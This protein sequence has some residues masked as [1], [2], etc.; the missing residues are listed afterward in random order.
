MS[1]GHAWGE[2]VAGKRVDLSVRIG[3]L[4]LRNPILTASGTFGYGDEYAH[5]VKIASLGGVVTKTVTVHPR[6]GNGPTRIAETASGMLNSIGLENVGL[7]RFRS[8][9]L[10]RLR[11]LDATVVASIG[12]ETPEELEELL[13]AL[14]DE[15]GVGAFEVNFSCPNVAAG[16]ARYWAD[17]ARLESTLRR[18]RHLTRR[19]L[20]AKLSPDVTD[21]RETAR[22]C[23]A[24]GADAL[25]CVN[26][27][28]GMAIDLERMRSKLGKAT[29]GLS[30]PAVKPMALARCWEASRAVKIPVIG[31]GGISSGRDALEFIAAG[32]AAV[33]VGTATFVEPGASLRV[34]DEMRAWLAA[35]GVTR[36]EDFRGMFDAPAA[37]AVG[38]PG[39]AK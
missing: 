33:Q 38:V 31:S 17:P 16:G 25:T 8:E 5:V 20:I 28:V 39:G 35:H 27:F 30:G 24:G 26:T 10:P 21:I 9:K 7:E 13:G 29:G 19:P 22:A 32:A 6:A 11:A 2:P 34:V 4:T 36:V 15:P 18:L 23:E 12:G 3:S 1:H 37:Q 14:G